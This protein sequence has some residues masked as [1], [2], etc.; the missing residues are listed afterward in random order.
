METDKPLAGALRAAHEIR[1]CQWHTDK[2]APRCVGCRQYAEIIARE[3]GLAELVEAVEHANGKPLESAHERHVDV[4]MSPESWN[5]VV[6]AARRV[7]E[8]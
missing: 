1:G 3:S 8:G 4:A 7:R 6:A 2:Q 5:R